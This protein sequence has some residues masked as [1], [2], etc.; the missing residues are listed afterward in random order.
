[1]RPLK[2]VMSAFGPYADRV[3][4]EMSELGSQG[5]YLITGDTGAG[6]TTIF[7]AI[8]FALFGSP[9]GANREVNML[10]SK[11]AA[12][13]TPTE[14]ELLFSHAGNS[15]LVKRNPEY[16]RPAKRGTGLKK[17][18]AN[19]EFTYPDG[20]VITKVKDV[21]AAIVE[22]LGI[23]R[24]Q[25]SQIAMLS[26][27]EFLK[28]LLADT[29][30]RQQIFRE[31]FKTSY[32]QT[33]Q[34]KL[35]DARKEIYSKVAGTKASIEQYIL[36]ISVSEEDVLKLEVDKA[37]KG[38]MTTIDIVE[39]IEKLLDNDRE[40]QDKLLSKTL[41]I[42]K[43]LEA[44]N[45]NIGKAEELNKIKKQL[46]EAK[47]QLEELKNK[48]DFYNENLKKSKEKLQNREEIL[49]KIA[50]IDAELIRYSELDNI[51]LEVKKDADLL[52]KLN[53]NF[54]IGQAEQNEKKEQYEA[55]KKEAEQLKDAGE[56]IE[57][58]LREKEQN[59]VQLRELRAVCDDIIAYENKLKDLYIMQEKY[60][61]DEEK[62]RLLKNKSD[63][64]DKA[65]MDGQAG[66]LAD[67]LRKNPN[68]P[69]PVCGSLE[70]PMLA[71]LQ[72]DVPTKDEL[73]H[74]K[75]LAENSRNIAIQSSS[76]AGEINSV[77]ENMLDNLNNK[78]SQM[79][80]VQAANEILELINN[81]FETNI[82]NIKAILTEEYK[83]KNNAIK[84]FKNLLEA[85]GKR[86]KRK[87]ETDRL[88]P[89][90][91]D[92]L[93]YIENGLTDL[94][95]RI[96][97]C[98]GKLE[99]D[100]KQ[101]ED[102][103]KGLSFENSNAAN[104][105][106]KLLEKECDY[107]QKMYEY[108]DKEYKE[109]FEKCSKL[110]GL[111]NGYE[112]TV[113]ASNEY[114]IEAEMTNKN[115]LVEE[116]NAVEAEQKII[117]IRVSAN[118]TA[119]VNINVKV[120]EMAV[121]EKKLQWMTALSNTANGKI[122]G[123]EKIMLETYVQTTYLDRILERANV[124]LMK[125]S[126]A[127]Y[128]LKRQSQAENNK[129]QT[130]LELDVVDHYNGT[131]RSVKTLSGGESFM[132]SLSLA[133]GLSDEVQASAG[134]IKIDSLFVDE[135]FGSLD[136]DSLELAFSALAGLTEGNR[137]VGIISHVSELKEKIDRQIVV[138]KQRSGG[139]KVK[140]EKG[141]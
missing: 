70:H 4:L 88:L 127:Q 20:R 119:R 55:L 54:N 89:E 58:L 23:D 109:Y 139:S 130:G 40:K 27:G 67:K 45:L 6:K 65:Y 41:E 104:E 138:T 25:F 100:K 56:K 1:M 72:S 48:E 102:I 124:R 125:M 15:Y 71:P 93:K 126:G 116:K 11:Y 96:S 108:A 92:R 87:E 141:C 52:A 90:Y 38:E 60:R 101:Q 24:E 115:I 35:D 135:G 82:D 131:V 62:Y 133:L 106:K 105:Q 86:V 107:L 76:R 118:D 50:A 136:S 22:L 43:K 94:R 19:A 7:D 49:K 73:E 66:I 69:C 30:S 84:E 78:M 14:V 110:N 123:K 68:Q 111:I 5:L 16:M 31:L 59:E 53:K 21:D 113:K 17:E 114:D 95:T 121:H 103:Q 83:A 99:A 122:S 57:K 132:A 61:Q 129:S 64:L 97:N 13:D 79:S 39:L 98:E 34:Y 77:L 47:N 128:E 18:M 2:L 85:E 42:D 120:D 140:I 3:E 112:T 32:Y 8:C 91:E 46:S 29:K 26:Q 63:A 10:R 44:V 37:K 28:L 137:L 51:A 81:D 12:V 36:G 80:F 134:G 75:T 33:L 9:S 117:N 74:A